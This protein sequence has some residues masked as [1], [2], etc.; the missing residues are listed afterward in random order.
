MVRVEAGTILIGKVLYVFYL[1]EVLLLNNRTVA[2]IVARDSLLQLS[3]H[4]GLVH[5]LHVLGGHS[6][7][8]THVFKVNV[9]RTDHIWI[10]ILVVRLGKVRKAEV[11]GVNRVVACGRA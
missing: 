9:A 4:E 11:A 7:R 2:E 1:L 6:M 8:A 3:L 10:G 5:V